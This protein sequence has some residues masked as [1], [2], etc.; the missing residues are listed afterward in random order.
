MTHSEFSTLL[1]HAFRD[2]TG[3][4]RN[5]RLPSEAGIRVSGNTAAAVL[6]LSATAVQANMQDDA[7]AFEAWALVLMV[8]CGVRRI[9]L[10]WDAPEQTGNDHYQRFLYRVRHFR[11]AARARDHRGGEAGAAGAMSGWQW[12]R[13][14]TESRR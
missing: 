12:R 3:T 11:P 7:A 10:D 5:I 1:R 8:W 9:T 6:R 2:H 14:D 13:R 4:R